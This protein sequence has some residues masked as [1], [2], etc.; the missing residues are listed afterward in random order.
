MNIL[1]TGSSK[2]SKYL[3]DE[4]KYDGHRVHHC[5]FEDDIDWERFD[6]FINCAHVE[7]EQS[8]MLYEAFKAYRNDDSKTIINISSR[9]VQPNISKGYLYAAQKSSLAHLSNNLTYN[10][11]KKCKVSTLHLGLLEHEE[12]PSLDYVEVL[13][14][15][16]MIA[17]RTDNI[18]IPE[19][20]IQHRANYQEV[21][22]DKTLLMETDEFFDLLYPDKVPDKIH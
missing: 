22:K 2:L 21:Q 15:V 9:A 19:I 3:G 17:F 6:V 12:L 18:D 1:I 7:W 10:S 8:K 5:R 13:G 4:L 20:T 16:K 14:F 11:D